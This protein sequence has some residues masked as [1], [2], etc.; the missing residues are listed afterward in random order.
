MQSAIRRNGLVIARD[1]LKFGPKHG[2]L[3]RAGYIDEGVFAGPRG[4]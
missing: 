4:G 3:C 1:G 2:V